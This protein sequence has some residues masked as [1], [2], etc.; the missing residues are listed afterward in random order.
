[1]ARDRTPAQH[2]GTGVARPAVD[3]RLIG[4]RAGHRDTASLVHFQKDKDEVPEQDSHP[5][6]KDPHHF[7]GP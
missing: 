5:F 4:D 1:M 7:R 6:S 3:V 2:V